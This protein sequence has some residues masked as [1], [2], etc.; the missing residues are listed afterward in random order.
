MIATVQRVKKSN[1]SVEKKIIADIKIGLN[2]FLGIMKNDDKSDAEYL[3]KKISTLRIFNDKNFNMNLSIKDVKGSLL[4]ISQFTLCADLKNGNRPS[5]TKA[6]EPCR[7]KKLYKHF[8]NELKKF[9][10]EVQSGKFGSIMDVSIR[11][12]GPAT[13]IL[14]SENV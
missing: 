8:I 11:N 9:D 14:D 6:A 2:V 3:A 10:L 7:A 13:F 12:D 1:V 4:V 5:F